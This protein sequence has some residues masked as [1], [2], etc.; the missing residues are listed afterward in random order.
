MSKR[1]RNLAA[2]TAMITAAPLLLAA[3]SSP[4][5]AVGTGYWVNNAVTCS[6]TGAGTQAAPFCTISQGTKKAVNPGDTVHVE[7]GT[8]REQITVNASGTATDPITVTV[9]VP[10]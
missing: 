2:G 9:T 5:A 4:A 1:L 10:A 6:D 7:P 8:Y 3:T